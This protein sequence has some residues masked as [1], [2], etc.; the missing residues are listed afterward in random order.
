MGLPK[1]YS[2]HFGTSPG[3]EN[4]AATHVASVWFESR[5][6]N[7]IVPRGIAA[8]R[9]MCDSPELNTSNWMEWTPRI[10]AGQ[11]NGHA[12]VWRIGKAVALATVL[13]SA[14]LLSFSFVLCVCTLRDSAWTFSAS[15]MVAWGWITAQGR[16]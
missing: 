6:G 16:T 15:A 5:R 11:A 12:A 10:G 1:D 4:P 3:D 7:V 13:R 8:T 14:H 9:A 2:W